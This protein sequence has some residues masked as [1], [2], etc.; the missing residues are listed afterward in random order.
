MSMHFTLFGRGL[1]LVRFDVEIR[2]V[3]VSATEAAITTGPVR[4][5]G[6]L[7]SIH[8]KLTQSGSLNPLEGLPWA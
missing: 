6:Q 4:A 7:M 2:V 3:I 1:H 5:V 8:A